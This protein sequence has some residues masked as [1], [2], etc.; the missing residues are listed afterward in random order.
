MAA[1]LVPRSSAAIAAAKSEK[2]DPRRSPCPIWIGH[3]QGG[4][5]FLDDLFFSS[6]RTN[7]VVVRSAGG[8]GFKENS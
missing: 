8:V 6:D 4:L 2:N 7:L 1:G 3:D 5:H